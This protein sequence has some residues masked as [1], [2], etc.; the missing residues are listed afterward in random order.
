ML[1]SEIERLKLMR[2]ASIRLFGCNKPEASHRT[3]M[4][5]FNKAPKSGFRIAVESGFIRKFK[6][7]QLK[8]FCKNCNGYH[9]PKSCLGA[10]VETLCQ[11]WIRKKFV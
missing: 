1:T 3:W 4:A 7:Q 8:D 11:S 9:S 5:Y 10:L 2:P 6:K